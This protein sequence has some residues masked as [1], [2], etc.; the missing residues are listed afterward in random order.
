MC[1]TYQ[2]KAHGMLYTMQQTL[3]NYDRIR[4]VGTTLNLYICGNVLV[5]GHF[6]GKLENHW[7][8]THITRENRYMELI[9]TKKDLSFTSTGDIWLIDMEIAKNNDRGHCHF[10]KSTC[11]IRDPA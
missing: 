3:S 5:C 2:I 4:K 8:I 11:D 6:W 1:P 10:L 7:E 9:G